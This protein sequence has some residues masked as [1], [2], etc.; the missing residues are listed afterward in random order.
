MPKDAD[1]PFLKLIHDV[2]DEVFVKYGFIIQEEEKW[3]QPETAIL[4]RKGDIE[5]AFRLWSSLLFWYFSLEI[6][7]LGKLGEEATSDL[8]YRSLGLESIAECLDT[9]YKINIKAAQTEEELRERMK[10]DKE[11]LIKYCE[12][13]LMGDVS[14]WKKTVDCLKGKA[15]SKRQ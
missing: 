4:A 2:F 7:L 1:I 9:N 14:N 5:L 6:S 15:E 8:K 3:T 10:S 13:I 11:E 12:D